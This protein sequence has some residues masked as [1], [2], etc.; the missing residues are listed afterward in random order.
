LHPAQPLATVVATYVDDANPATA[1][2][3]E[4]HATWGNRRT[5]A[6]GIVT[7]NGV[8]VSMPTGMHRW[9]GRVFRE[10]LVG[11]EALRNPK[12]LAA[13]AAMTVL[14]A[15]E[16]SEG[17]LLA[18][19][20]NHNFF[21]WLV[22]QLPRLETVEQVS[23][24]HDVPLLVPATAP[25]FVAE[26]LRLSGFEQ[27]VRHL[28]DGVYRVGT[29]HIPSPLST[30]ADVSPIAMEWLDTHLPTA[31][32]TGP[33]ASTSLVAT[34]PFATSPTRRRSKRCSNRSTGSRPW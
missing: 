34:H 13:F 15:D 32:A 11:V 19:P 29:L 6:P 1:R 22:E 8:D 7:A 4:M 30:T 25:P 23:E 9:R 33:H 5:I 18:L 20:W 27:R 31:E 16:L 26:S 28:E 24:L 12:Y 14:G 17:V 2:Y 21:H 3:L 10:G